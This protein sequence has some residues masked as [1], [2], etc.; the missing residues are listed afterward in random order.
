MYKQT[1]T[2]KITLIG[3]RYAIAVI[4]IDTL[5]YCANFFS[6]FNSF[7]NYKFPQSVE[8]LINP[9]SASSAGKLKNT[10]SKNCF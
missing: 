8:L 6:Y 5:D 7:S 9:E 3:D 2:D 4:G 1:R 10:T